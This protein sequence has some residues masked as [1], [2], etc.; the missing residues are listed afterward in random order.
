MSRIQSSVGLI[1]GIPIQETVDKLMEVAFQPKNILTDRTNLLQSEQAAVTQ[2]T[3]LI[4]AFQ[5]E[6]SKLGSTQLFDSKTVSSSK[7]TVLSATLASGGNPAAG[8][9]LFTPV[10]TASAQQVLSQS[11]SKDAAVGAGELTFQIGGFV[12]KG[13]SLDELNN[14]DGVQRGQIR[15][16]DRNGGTAL[17][18]LSYARTVDDVLKAINT[19]TS[20]NVTATAVGDQFTLTDNT[21][22]S[23]NLIVQDVAGG[24]T[25]ADLGLA[26]INVAASSATGTDVFSL[27]A[28]T[29]LSVLN[30][31]NGVQLK[32]GDDLAV[33]LADESTLNI[34]LSG[35]TTLGDVVTA[36][37]AADPAKLTAAIS[38]DGNRLELTDLTAGVGAFAV[39]SVG[40]GTAAEDLG[41]TTT[42]AGDTTTGSRLVSGLRDTLVSSL[43]GGQGLGTLGQLDITNRDNVSFSVDLSAAETLG[44][45]VA[46]INDQSTDVTASIN[47]ARNG[48][49]L[50]DVSGGTAVNFQVADGDANESATA[51]GI[52]VDEAATTV[53]SGSLA[54]QQV[55]ESTLLASL[56][57]G[58][59]IKV[60][61]FIVKDSTGQIGA[62]DL[63]PT[64]AVAV[65]VG[66]VID[67]I[68]A[69]SIGVEAR[70]NDEGDGIVLIDTAGGSDQ[71]TVSEVGSGTTAADLRIEGNSVEVDINGTPTQV[72]NGTAKTTVTIGAEDTLVDL[73][74]AIN[75][76]A[77][78]VSASIVTDS[79]GQR[80]SI[81]GEV[82]AANELLFDASGSTLKLQQIGDARD[83][84]L[85]Y[86]TGGSAGS[87]VLFAS[88]SNT[89]AD[90]VDGVNLV[91]KDGSLDPV[92]V[93]VSASSNPIVSGVQDFVDAYN[94]IRDL[95]DQATDFDA[96]SLTT[97]ILFGSNE[98]LRVESEL[99]RALTTRYFGVGD[100][101]SVV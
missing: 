75:D 77:A 13:I 59:G 16:T 66:D 100:R 18:D 25:A 81:T 20:I 37:N 41:L 23:G 4:V 57:Q 62:V 53:N 45:I 90:V 49:V 27:H 39:A 91:V 87:G 71:L 101:K 94:S 8:S 68:N 5:F 47:T 11:Y 19:N 82:G 6:A 60:G 21:G 54:R 28:G 46:A 85:L 43:R 17:I 12:D 29:K 78:G 10:Q 98:A 83:A 14:G 93:S 15:V 36:I 1:S 96:E 30:D 2:L 65:T 67:R 22:G 55:S 52:V 50:N 86:G 76:L 38:A 95:L 42:A 97:G 80:L 7:S 34:D 72:I 9:Y 33:T 48:I 74:A 69:L 32:S 44:E 73:A 61:D 70:I 79:T 3:S 31:G 88:S 89:F 64:D 92:T 51:L 58:K 26:G 99:T 24:T 84:L 56:N 40:T 35:A 63:N